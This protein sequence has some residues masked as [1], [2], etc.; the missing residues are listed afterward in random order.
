MHWHGRWGRWWDKGGDVKLATRLLT[1]YWEQGRSILENI[2]LG[3]HLSPLGAGVKECCSVC[4]LCLIV[5]SYICPMQAALLSLLPSCHICRVIKCSLHSHQFLAIFVI[6]FHLSQPLVFCTSFRPNR[7]RSFAHNSHI[8]TSGVTQQPRFF[9][10]EN[11]PVLLFSSICHLGRPLWHAWV[12]LK[13]AR[14]LA[15][16]CR[17]DPTH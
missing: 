8:F 3:S 9:Y 11:C 4:S 17:G 14:V 10:T 16:W 7:D 15:K 5:C 1:A 13:W 6:C 2:W 12:V